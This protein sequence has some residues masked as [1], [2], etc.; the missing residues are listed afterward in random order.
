MLAACSDKYS[1]LKMVVVHSSGTLVNICQTVQHTYHKES[2]QF[3]SIRQQQFDFIIFRCVTVNVGPRDSS[4][5]YS[6]ASHR[7][8]PALVMWNLW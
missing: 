7:V 4:G 2:T 5:G 6:P 3:P 1:V 8:G